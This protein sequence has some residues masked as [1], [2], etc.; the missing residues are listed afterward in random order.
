MSSHKKSTISVTGTARLDN[1]AG[2]VKY[3]VSRKLSENE[4]LNYIINGEDKKDKLP[5]VFQ[6]TWNDRK[7]Y[8]LL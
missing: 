6:L 4:I 5:T 7:E 1:A 3:N 8:N 2:Y